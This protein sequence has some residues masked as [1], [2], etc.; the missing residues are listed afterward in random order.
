MQTPVTKEYCNNQVRIMTNEISDVKDAVND[1]RVDVARMP[2]LILEKSEGKFA[3]KTTEKI[4]YALVGIICLA[5]IGS[6][7]NSV[8]VTN[9]SNLDEGTITEILEKHLEANYELSD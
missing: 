9:K 4:V 7:V 8:V 5:V 6:V 2:E 1:L 3:S